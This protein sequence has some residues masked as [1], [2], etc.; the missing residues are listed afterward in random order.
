M[1]RLFEFAMI[2]GLAILAQIS[3]IQAAEINTGDENGAY[4]SAF[5]P[6]LVKQLDALGTPSKC[7]RTN[8]TGENVRRVAQFPDQLG[9]AQLDAYVLETA[10]Q[11]GQGAFEIIRG[12]RKGS[13]DFYAPE[14]VFAVTRN[15]NLEIY[16][17][18]AANA[19][20][21]NFYLPPQSSGSSKTFEYLRKLD[22]EGIGTAENITHSFTATEAVER[23]LA[24][25]R[26]VAFFVQFPDPSN[27]L[28]KKIRELKGH[29][30][31][32][33]DKVLLRKLGDTDVYFEQQTA[34]RQNKLLHINLGAKVATICT[35]MILFTGAPERFQDPEKKRQ[36]RQLISLIRGMNQKDLVPETS[37]M[38]K[39]LKSTEALT[40]QARYH[41]QEL[42]YNAR[43]RARPFID[44]IYRGAGH[45]VKL[46]ILKARPPEYQE[47]EDRRGKDSRSY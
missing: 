44:R 3:A 39:I 7:L 12:D 40:R 47:V 9:F 46:M 18:I 34:I 17:D 31:P 16:G 2:G 25:E 6:N 36:Q 41:F 45:W 8:G 22:N 4:Y 11:G 27:D 38:G 29:I 28:F 10:K 26:S 32:V 5:C 35:P 20:L 23:A 19:R 30:V 33:L 21:L 37:R 24:D 42:S 13:P 1:P 14:C 15:K 43:E